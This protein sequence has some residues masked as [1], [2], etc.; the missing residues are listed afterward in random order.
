MTKKNVKY[1]ETD[2]CVGIGTINN[3]EDT[4]LPPSPLVMKMPECLNGF[5]LTT[6]EKSRETLALII[7]ARATGAID[8]ETAQ[9]LTWM[10]SVYLPAHRAEK[11][12]ELEKKVEALEKRF[13]I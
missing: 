5:D 1:H 9:S 2:M 12:T 6:P 10:M 11:W 8:K 3:P 7:R 13:K 4:A